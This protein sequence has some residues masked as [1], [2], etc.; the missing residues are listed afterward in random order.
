M[1]KM[2]VLQMPQ[3]EQSTD[4]LKGSE[5]AMPAVKQGLFNTLAFSAGDTLTKLA[6]DFGTDKGT[7][8][9]DGHAYTLVYDVLF[10]TFQ[11]QPINLLEVGLALGGPELKNDANRKV[12]DAPSVRLWH[13]Y[14][15]NAHIY[16]ADI[17]DFS[18][19]QTEWFSF[20]RMDCGNP[21]E[22]EQV[23]QAGVQFDIIIDDGSHASFHQ[24]LTMLKFWPLLRS[25]GLY[26]IE[27]L[28]WQP[29]HYERALP[30]APKTEKQLIN[31]IATGRFIGTG[32]LPSKEWFPIARTIRNVMLFDN[33]QLAG[34]RQ[35]Y[36][37]VEGCKA[38]VAHYLESPWP[39]RML[40]RAHVRRLFRTVGVCTQVLTGQSRRGHCSPV[41]LAVIHKARPSEPA[42]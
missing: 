27:D 40:T 7:I 18:Q 3:M 12:T 24:Q 8:T 36:N 33:D 4:S 26:I 32:A 19:F 35:V 34:M 2:V 6:N 13:E 10:K 30:P 22:L 37:R 25:G 38:A 29:R 9:R 39:Q 15:P 5:P 28:Q 17:S 16:G 11:Y 20:F 21:E 31:F 23:A 42:R 1:M 41:T 14:F